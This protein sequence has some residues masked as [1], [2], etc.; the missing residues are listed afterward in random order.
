MPSTATKKKLKAF[1]FVEGGPEGVQEETTNKENLVEM[2]KDTVH[3]PHDTLAKPSGVAA[4]LSAKNCPP[5]TPENPS[6]LPLNQLIGNAAFSNR[7]GQIPIQQE[8]ELLWRQATPLS[9]QRSITPARKRKRPRS[10]SPP[11]AGAVVRPQPNAFKTPKQDPAA[12]IW[13]R[14]RG[15]VN[16]ANSALQASQNGI[17]NLLIHSSPRSSATAGSVGG[18]RRYNS[19][20]YQWPTSRKKRKVN[21]PPRDLGIGIVESSED[22][23]KEEVKVPKVSKVSLFLEEAGRIR[24][25]ERQESMPNENGEEEESPSISSPLQHPRLVS[26]QADVESPLQNRAPASTDKQRDLQ[27]KKQQQP[28]DA[29]LDEF[30][31][32]PHS[33]GEFSDLDMDGADLDALLE[34]TA[35]PIN[36]KLGVPLEK[37]DQIMQMDA[38]PSRAAANP[39]ENHPEEKDQVHVE[40]EFDEFDDDDALSDN[41]WAQAALLAEQQTQIPQN[42]GPLLVPEVIHVESSPATG[43]HYHEILPIK[44]PSSDEFGDDIGVDDFAAAE[45]LATQAFGAG[46]VCLR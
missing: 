19:C 9:S 12:E 20:G 8:E 33:S 46:T 29:C 45:A 22:E 1:Q 23:A 36:L 25:L 39:D 32:A 6:R 14:Y 41:A 24:D 42:Q 31:D 34:S 38:V 37:A 26:E 18:L 2:G 28:E 11:S 27:V 21:H 44:E 40:D 17:E 13:S 4:V 16:N 3:K 35:A 30:G 43:G 10:S 15:D 5:S 7:A